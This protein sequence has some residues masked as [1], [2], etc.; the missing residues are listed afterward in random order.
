MSA[1]PL[2]RLAGTSLAA[3]VAGT[4]LTLAAGETASAQTAAAPPPAQGAAGAQADSGAGY[5]SLADIETR[6][7]A[8]GYSDIR[9]IEHE[10]PTYEVKARTPAGV[11]SELDVDARSGSVLRVEDDD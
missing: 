6:L 5:L 4:V 8:A 2:K 1:N 10:G 3:L 11:F 9:E 7:L